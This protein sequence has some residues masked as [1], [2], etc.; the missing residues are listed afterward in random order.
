MKS[1]SS[2]NQALS[3]TIRLMQESEFKDMP[4]LQTHAGTS[5]DTISV[6]DLDA[7][8]CVQTKQ[9]HCNTADFLTD[10]TLILDSDT[11]PNMPSLTDSSHENYSESKTDLEMMRRLT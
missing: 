7:V 8:I 11:D 5:M 6:S 9:P 1:N 3:T 10:F 4:K 2:L